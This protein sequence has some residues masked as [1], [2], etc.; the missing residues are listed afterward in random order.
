MELELWIDV[1]CPWCYL[2]KRRLEAAL[3]QFDARD[4]VRLVE[5]SFEL[6]PSAAAIKQGSAAEEVAAKY[7][8]S[9][10][11]IEVRHAQMVEL[12]RELGIEFRFDISRGGNTFDAH[13]LIHLARE[14]GVGEAVVE[15]LM[16]GY[17]SEGMAIGDPAELARA[18]SEAGIPLP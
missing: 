2:G 11:E 15:R 8:L 6:D 17:F 12:G 5:R 16:S 9:V 7:G 3:E 1:V 13:R 18:A 4:E 14:Q 10:A